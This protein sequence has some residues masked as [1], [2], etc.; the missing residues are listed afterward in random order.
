VAQHVIDQAGLQMTERIAKHNERVFASSDTTASGVDY[1]TWKRTYRYAIRGQ[2]AN[3]TDDTDH[4]PT[5]GQYQSPHG[6]QP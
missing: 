6:N 3:D 5:D 1:S 2:M 4:G